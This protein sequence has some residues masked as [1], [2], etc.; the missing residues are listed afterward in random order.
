M[1]NRINNFL[2]NLTFDELKEVKSKVE[3]MMNNYDDGFKYECKLLSYGIKST[4]IL[5]N[6]YSV[7]ELCNKYDALEGIVDVYTTNPNLN[8]HNYGDTYYFPTLEDAEKWRLYTHLKSNIDT[9]KKE[10]NE[11][12]NPLFKPRYSKQDVENYEKQILGY[13]KEMIQPVKLNYN[14]L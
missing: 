8:I 11:W 4:I 1:S 14:E 6:P 9:W 5:N 7:Q 10:L 3:D 13:E 2:K 12:E